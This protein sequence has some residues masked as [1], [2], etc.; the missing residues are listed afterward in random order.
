MTA[1]AKIINE[2]ERLEYS[3]DRVQAAQT[4][5]I[6]ISLYR[7]DVGAVT[8]RIADHG[9]AYLP[10]RPQLRIDVSPENQTIKDA[11][12]MLR[13]PDTIPAVQRA[14]LDSNER[15]SITL[16]KQRETTDRANTAV[17]ALAIREHLISEGI[18]DSEG[19][20]LTQNG[21]LIDVESAN[22]DLARQIAAQISERPGRVYM[23]LTGRKF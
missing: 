11:I 12:D 1:E 23:A 20:I 8:V 7:S 18:I 2:A 5:T 15:R 9:E 3:V 4:G 16:Q 19:K 14:E 22:R 10:E 6:Y 21:K 17:N 13:R